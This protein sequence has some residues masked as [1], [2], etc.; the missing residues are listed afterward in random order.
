MVFK[1]E[2]FRQ[3]RKVRAL[4]HEVPEV[5][6]AC[7]DVSNRCRDGG[8]GGAHMENA[9][10]ERIQ[11]NIRDSSDHAADH[12]LTAGAF[13]AD[14]EARGG[15]PDDERGTVGD[16]EDIAFREVVCLGIR[17]ENVEDRLHE[18]D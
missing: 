11:N 9:D 15:G 4:F 12:G 1:A 6:G 17:A 10:H 3:D 2:I 16:M 18:E 13:G 8:T 5:V 14:N 7:Q